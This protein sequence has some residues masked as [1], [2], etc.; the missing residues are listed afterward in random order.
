MSFLLQEIPVPLV[1]LLLLIGTSLPFFYRLFKRFSVRKS[2]GFIFQ[3]GPEGRSDAAAP[4]RKITSHAME[5]KVLQLLASKKESGML[6]R[7]IADM[8]QLDTGKTGKLLGYLEGK[9]FIESVNGMH[10]I[11]YYLTDRG[12][13]YCRKKGYLK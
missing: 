5:K 3:T 6:D 12:K 10:G 8:L 4:G 13:S 9:A 7:S 11:K 2:S 1:L